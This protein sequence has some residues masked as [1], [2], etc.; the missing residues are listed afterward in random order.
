MNSSVRSITADPAQQAAL[1]ADL[2]QHWSS[3]NLTAGESTRV[4]SEYLEVTCIRRLNALPSRKPAFP[5]NRHHPNEI[6]SDT[7]DEKGPSRQI[8]LQVSLREVPPLAPERV[9][10]VPN[11][12]TSES[13]T[14]RLTVARSG[15]TDRSKRPRSHS[16]RAGVPTRRRRSVEVV[17][18]LPE[19]GSGRGGPCRSS[20]HC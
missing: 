3:H 6:K 9:F 16:V 18:L 5:E 1:R 10:G 19:G 8:P 7:V 2:E 4:E 12:Q 15:H 13:N 14:H 20:T 11:E 17:G